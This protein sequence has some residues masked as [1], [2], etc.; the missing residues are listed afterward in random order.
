MM[1]KKCPCGKGDMSLTTRE[2]RACVNGVDVDVKSES[3]V[4][5]CCG[6]EVGTVVQASAAQKAIS[7]EYRKKTG[8]LTGDEIKKMRMDRGL[9]TK[10]LA[11]LMNICEGSIRKWES[12]LV[13]DFTMD[14]L[15]RK[16]LQ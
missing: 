12:S 3:Y 5:P 7:D 4:C 9:S 11:D 13:Q 10:Q 14:K 1:T 2:K 8:L 6:I 15:L 16:I